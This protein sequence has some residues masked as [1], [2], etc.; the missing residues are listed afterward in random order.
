MG[1][2]LRWRSYRVGRADGRSSQDHVRCRLS[3]DGTNRGSVTILFE[4]THGVRGSAMAD[5]RPNVM[6]VLTDQLARDFVGCYGGEPA[7]TPRLDA[8]ARQGVRLNQAYVPLPQ[9]SPA[10]A[11]MFTGRYPHEHQLYMNGYPDQAW[12]IDG[13]WI[14]NRPVLPETV[15]SLG[16]AF[17]RAGYRMGYTGPW[18]MGRDET[19]QHGWTDSWRTYRYWASGLDVYEQRLETCGFLDMFHQEHRAVSMADASSTDHRQPSMATQIP[20]EHTRTAWAVDEA[21][22][23]LDAADGRPWMFCCSIKDPHP[24]V[25]P[26]SD[27]ADLVSPDAVGLPESFSDD[28]EGKPALIRE[29][30]AWKW[31]SYM[32]NHQWRQYIAHYHGLIA[33]IDAEVGRLIDGLEARGL[34]DDTILIFLSDHGEMMGAHH[35]AH[36]GPFMYDEVYAIPFIAHW[37]GRVEGGMAHDDFFSTVDFV[38][39]IGGLTGVEV[40]DGSGYDQSPT[41]LRG[42]R[43][44]RSAVF[45]EFY[46][47]N[48]DQPKPPASDHIARCRIKSVRTVDWKMNVY[49]DDRSELYDLRADPAEMRNLIDEPV[50]ADIRRELGDR[51][52]EWLRATGDP[53]ADMT[54]RR[55][56]ELVSGI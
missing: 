39:T 40:D 4:S 36:K 3:P 54:E 10:R 30:F 21:L 56:G 35:M 18:H 38:A 47:Q 14:R 27:T 44:L 31:S 23:F 12:E 37:P 48:A 8:L 42:D 51:I 24:P 22:T 19:P 11:S 5:K 26:P 20:G 55:I 28:L 52:M 7:H 49:Q 45:S 13:G 1:T 17:N 15:P 46:G 53:M 41:L 32:S 34:R 16:Q 9:C 33:H 29:T 50:H 6:I 43:G 2:R 25:L